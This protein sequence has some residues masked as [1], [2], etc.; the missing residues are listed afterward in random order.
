M[1]TKEKKKS[2]KVK[3]IIRRKKAAASK[4]GGLPKSVKALLGYLVKSDTALSGSSA[5]Q[6]R[7][8]APQVTQQQQQQQQQQQPQF[9]FRARAAQGSVIGKSPLTA[10]QAAAPPAPPAQNIVIKTTAPP[11]QQ[12]RD[13]TKKD[14]TKIPDALSKLNERV[15]GIEDMG[16][17]AVTGIQ[18]SLKR[19]D[20]RV[21]FFEEG[22]EDVQT[23]QTP[24]IKSST[25][26][27]VKETRFGSAVS[28]GD[29][30]PSFQSISPA[31]RLSFG[32]AQ[33]AALTE[34]DEADDA[35]S[36]FAQSHIQNVTNPEMQPIKKLRG[37][38]PGTKL[39]P[40]T[41]ESYRTKRAA[42]AS[43]KKAQSQQLYQ[44]LEQTQATNLLE[45][46]A[47]KIMIKPKQRLLTPRKR[48]EI[49]AA[50]TASANIE[51][52]VAGGGAAAATAG[53]TPTPPQSV[54]RSGTGRQQL[55]RKAKGGGG[56]SNTD[57]V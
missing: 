23:L 34:D 21:K 36:F 22:W 26:P 27:V 16:K 19:M 5:P 11:P 32:G 46:A 45:T 3:V 14:D 17:R 25:R 33:A 41:L 30:Q 8:L 42:T 38:K 4:G 10:I 35:R 18:S 57:I 48:A 40:T 47:K 52:L 20:Q 51:Q 49:D 39:T 31:R 15:L 1:V 43:A 12:Q 24:A 55:G 37:R 6:P 7:Q 28:L 50:L 29:I 9:V 54:L 56:N 13:D 53:H 2:K 44:E